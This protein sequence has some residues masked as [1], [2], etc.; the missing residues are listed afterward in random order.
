VLHTSAPKRECAAMLLADAGVPIFG[1][2]FGEAGVRTGSG[3]RISSLK[4]LR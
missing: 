3:G 4:S 2:P 1:L